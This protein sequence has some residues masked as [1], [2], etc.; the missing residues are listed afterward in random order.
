[1]AFS[2]QELKLRAFRRAA[3]VLY[4]FWEEQKDYVPR[5]AA[6]HSRLF[7]TLIYNEYI[8]LNRK[9]PGRRYP[10]HVVPCAYIRNLAFEMYWHGDRP[11]DV[12]VI[13]GRLLRIAYISA[14][15]ARAVDYLHKYTMPQNWDPRTG[16]IT[17]RLELVG[18]TIEEPLEITLTIRCIHIRVMSYN[19]ISHFFLVFNSSTDSSVLY[20]PSSSPICP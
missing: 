17:A 11:D 5:S 4:S 20:N 14:E 10:E 8:E 13:S 19:A 12:A 15:Q 16:S 3:D 2:R 1:M 9:A 18:I 7:D 6:V